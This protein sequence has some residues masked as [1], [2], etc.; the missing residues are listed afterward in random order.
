MIRPKKTTRIEDCLTGL[1]ASLCRGADHLNGR[2]ETAVANGRTQTRFYLQLPMPA[3]SKKLLSSYVRGYVKAS[4][5]R[6]SALQFHK[7]YVL[8]ETTSVV[9]APARSRI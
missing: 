6:V 9:T 4:G 7:G 1:L 8:L 3:E 5:W 2:T